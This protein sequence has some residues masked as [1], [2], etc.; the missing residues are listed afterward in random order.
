MKLPEIK[1]YKG[2]D[3][4]I[5]VSYSHRDK[6]KV[7]PFIA[8]LQKKYNVWFDEGIHYGQEWEKEI[9]DRLRGCSIFVF[10][11]TGHSL[12]SENCMDELYH[13]R[14]LKKNFINVLMEEGT[15]LPEW[16][17]FRYARYQMCDCL[18]F[19]SPEAAIADIE[20]KCGWFKEARKDLPST[21]TTKIYES[22]C[23]AGLKPEETGSD[24][25]VITVCKD[26]EAEERE[27]KEKAEREAELRSRRDAIERA[28]RILE[29]NSAPEEAAQFDASERIEGRR[30]PKEKKPSDVCKKCGNQLPDGAMFC[31][32]C[33]AK[34]APEEIKR[35]NYCEWCG[36][37]LQPGAS[38][39]TSCGKKIRSRQ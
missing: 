1:A 26:N 16:F 14:T 4:Y 28:R 6:E 31:T 17:T 11:I 24:K 2:K 39:C 12:D 29:E 7:Y 9:A 34:R 23:D 21:T 5:F 13:A 8:A 37:R 15:E 18:S 35:S 10:F 33:G 20:R 32:H 3:N 22:E 38:F 25:P 30:R 27:A 19:P 36:A